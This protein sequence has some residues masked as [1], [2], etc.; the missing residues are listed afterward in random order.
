MGLQAQNGC[1]HPRQTAPEANFKE[2]PALPAGETLH[3][4]I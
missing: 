3:K 4:K 1:N 2:Q